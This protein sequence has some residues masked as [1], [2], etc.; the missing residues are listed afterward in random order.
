MRGAT[1]APRTRQFTSRHAAH[2][3]S[4]HGATAFAHRETHAGL[5]RHGVTQLELH[6]GAL[7]WPELTF[8]E[9]ELARHVRRAE[10]ELR[11]VAGSAG[12]LSPAFLGAEQEHLRATGA[13]GSDR[14]ARDQSLTAHHLVA[15][16]AAQEQTD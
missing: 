8:G 10:I 7:T 15:T 1:S 14:P 4:A 6:L 5:E 9:D 2:D 16:Y 3:A 11:R 12:G 13:V